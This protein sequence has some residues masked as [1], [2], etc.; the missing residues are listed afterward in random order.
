MDTLKLGWTHYVYYTTH[1]FSA[2]SYDSCH[3]FWVKMTNLFGVS[4]LVTTYPEYSEQ[5]LLCNKH[6]VSNPILRYP[7]ILL[8][9]NVDGALALPIQQINAGYLN[10]GAKILESFQ[11]L[12]RFYV[13]CKRR[14]RGL[15]PNI[16]KHR[17]LNMTV[18]LAQT[19]QLIYL[20]SHFTLNLKQ[21]KMQN[22]PL[23]QL[24]CTNFRDKI[25]C[26][27]RLQWLCFFLENIYVH[28]GG[29]HVLQDTYFACR[30]LL[31]PR[32]D[33]FS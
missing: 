7:L 25:S 15:L 22:R 8:T 16:I 9:T 30:I 28:L 4:I 11:W 33:G 17:H 20:W 27:F 19:I 31:F 2:L 24:W 32:T 3:V 1:L 21:I 14:V 18:A 26:L 13:V 10:D 5:T 29:H 12:V 6:N 23:F